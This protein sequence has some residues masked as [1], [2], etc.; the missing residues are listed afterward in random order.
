MA[1]GNI[2]VCIPAYFL[3]CLIVGDDGEKKIPDEGKTKAQFFFDVGTECFV[4]CDYLMI[5]DISDRHPP[6]RPP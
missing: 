3:M 2:L 5:Q 6:P 1:D 4:I